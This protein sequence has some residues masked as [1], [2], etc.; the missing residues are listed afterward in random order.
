MKGW[1]D[2]VGVL[3][4][5]IP[6]QSN[7][8]GRAGVCRAGLAGSCHHRDRAKQAGSQM[9]ILLDLFC[10]AGGAGM[11]YHLAGFDVVGVDIEPQPNYPFECVQA[12]AIEY[13]IKD[14]KRFDA[15][16]ASP[17]CQ[18][19]SKAAKI[20]KRRH[21]DLIAKT[22]DAMPAGK[23]WVIENVEGSPLLNPITLC[24]Y[25]F[26]L[27]TYRHRLFESSVKLKAPKHRYHDKRITK[28]GRPPKP[29]E[30][31][32][33]IGNFS[34]VSAARIAMGIDWMTRNELREAIPPA[35]T[36]WIGKQVLGVLSQ[37][38]DETNGERRR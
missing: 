23:P 18:A 37:T 32:H 35:Y 22:R 13:L 25:S 21:P 36:K 20:M 31:M 9:P 33:V 2:A 24:G 11:G 34:G 8:I 27:R 4:G 30:M 10:K 7:T 5:S 6:R 12:D 1:T 19:Y 16:H 15:I 14:G 29:G 28:M 17:P 26:N 3:L 38:P